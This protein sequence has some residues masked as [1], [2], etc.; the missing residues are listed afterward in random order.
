MIKLNIDGQRYQLTGQPSISEWQGLM[1]YD[2]NDYDQWSL[3]LNHTLGIELSTIEQMDWEQKKL[4]IVM[5]AHSITERQPI[6]LPDFNEIKFGAFI[7]ME[8]YLTMGLEKTINE[9]LETLNVEAAHAQEALYALENYVAWRTSLY[10]QYRELFSYD[11]PDMD[12]VIADAGKQSAIEVAKAWYNILVE[13]SNDNVLHI[14]KVTELGVREALNFMAIR[15]E[16]QLAE[17][18]AAKQRQRQYDVQRNSR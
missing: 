14:N 8:Y 15:K 3:I 10:K 1:K 18:R 17:Q 2:F 16:K 13:L 7:D 4:A 9:A 11:D 6:K 5:I 12:E